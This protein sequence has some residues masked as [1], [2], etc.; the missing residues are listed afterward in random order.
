MPATTEKQR[1]FMGA[2]LQRKREGKKTRTD[3]TENAR[4]DGQQAGWQQEKLVMAHISEIR[5]ATPLRTPRSPSLLPRPM[6][7]PSLRTNAKRPPARLPNPRREVVSGAKLRDAL[8][9]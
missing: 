1:R 6:A 8:R 5:W 9:W 2:E 4:E 7:T 3:M